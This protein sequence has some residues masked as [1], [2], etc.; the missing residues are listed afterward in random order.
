[1]EHKVEKRAIRLID[2][3]NEA[4]A[5]IDTAIAELRKTIQFSKKL[6]RLTRDRAQARLE[7]TRSDL[8]ELIEENSVDFDWTLLARLHIW[9]AREV[10]SDAFETIYIEQIKEEWIATA[11]S[12]LYASKENCFERDVYGDDR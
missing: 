12:E 6:W 7:R 8:V 5:E 1:M 4:A 3:M 9:H 11:E 2:E 10:Y